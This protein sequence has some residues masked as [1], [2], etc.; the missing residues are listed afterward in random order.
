MHAAGAKPDQ[1]ILNTISD[2]RPTSGC[3]LVLSNDAVSDRS[4]GMLDPVVN[5]TLSYSPYH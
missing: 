4:L 1:G 3:L 2:P 5:G